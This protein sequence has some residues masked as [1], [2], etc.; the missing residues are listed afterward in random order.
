MTTFAIEGFLIV[1][2]ELMGFQLIGVTELSVTNITDIRTF[3]G[4][5]T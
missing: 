3:S 1:V 4:V 5:N 2:K